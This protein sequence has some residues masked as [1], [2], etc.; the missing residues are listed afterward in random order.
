VILFFSVREKDS[1]LDDTVDYSFLLVAEQF[2]E[3]YID[4]I[5][6]FMYLEKWDSRKKFNYIHEIQTTNDN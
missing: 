4:I 5:I 1:L 3:I 2:N 6:F